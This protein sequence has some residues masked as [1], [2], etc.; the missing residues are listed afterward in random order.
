[1]FLWNKLGVEDVDCRAAIDFQSMLDAPIVLTP[2]GVKI[3]GSRCCLGMINSVA[4]GDKTRL[5]HEPTRLV[6]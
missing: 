1:M 3:S 6:G 4:D 2:N 5:N